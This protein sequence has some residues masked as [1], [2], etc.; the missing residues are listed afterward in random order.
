MIF[1]LNRSKLIKTISLDSNPIK[2]IFKNKLK[3][4]QQ[5]D[6]FET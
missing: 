5:M 2:L 6:L 3:E 1:M 4:H